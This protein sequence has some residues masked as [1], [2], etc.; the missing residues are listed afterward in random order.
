MFMK[1]MGAAMVPALLW[2]QGVSAG[3]VR[4]ECSAG[5]LA[6]EL[7]SGG[8]IRASATGPA[9]AYARAYT[10]GVEIIADWALTGNNGYTLQFQVDLQRNVNTGAR[11]NTGFGITPQTNAC[12]VFIMC[13]QPVPLQAAWS[14]TASGSSFG[15]PAPTL[16]DNQTFTHELFTPV[17][18]LNEGAW[19]T[20]IGTNPASRRLQV[21]CNASTYASAPQTSNTTD[22]MLGTLSLTF[23]FTNSS[24]RFAAAPEIMPGELVFHLDDSALGQTNQLE[25]A[26]QVQAE[27]WDVITN[28]VGQG[29]GSTL[30]ISL[31][32]TPQPRFYRTRLR[33]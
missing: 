33:Q 5:T 23:G 20:T 16:T 22:R 32:S 30:R 21:Y 27:A 10:N 25:M 15:M 13:D 6:G 26:E 17:G 14:V 18:G 3:V 7:V 19:N 8:E 28:F 31:P 12:F 9:A 4:T 11:P 29:T 1:F 24:I 2:L